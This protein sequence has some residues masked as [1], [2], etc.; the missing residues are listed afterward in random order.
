MPTRTTRHKPAQESAPRPG[1]ALAEQLRAHNLRVTP[2][3]QIV[4]EALF[5]A[6]GHATAE[7]LLQIAQ[8]KLPGFN[9]ASVYRTLASLEDVSLI[10]S[11]Q[12]GHGGRVY[13]LLRAGE[14]GHQ[15]LVCT[16]CGKTIHFK[17]TSATALRRDLEKEHGFRVRGAE[18]IVAGLCPECAAELDAGG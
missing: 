11:S 13:E 8:E 5:N 9:I 15:H 10:R 6:E 4:L 3:R 17:A 12:L 2:Q 16:N 18:I 1:Y 14:E 7:E